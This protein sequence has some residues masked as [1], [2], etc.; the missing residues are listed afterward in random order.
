MDD[1]PEREI[2]QEDNNDILKQ[3]MTKNEEKY[4][5]PVSSSVNKTKE[6]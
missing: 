1:K 4:H 6:S 3:I 5:R 2:K